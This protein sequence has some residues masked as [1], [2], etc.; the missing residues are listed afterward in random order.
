MGCQNAELIIDPLQKRG[1]GVPERR[2]YCST[3]VKMQRLAGWPHRPPSTSASDLQR[4]ASATATCRG[5]TLPNFANGYE[6]YRLPTA[7]FCEVIHIRG[8]L[9]IRMDLASIVCHWPPCLCFIL[10]KFA[11]G[12]EILRL[13]TSSCQLIHIDMSYIVCHEPPCH[14]FASPNYFHRSDFYRR[15]PALGACFIPPNMHMDL[16]SRGSTSP[17]SVLRPSLLSTWT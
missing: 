7:S 14:C 4:P 8:L 6:L 16:I 2:I 11:L 13:S 1:L 12:S 9:C 3:Q 5:F 15:P 17:K 10:Y